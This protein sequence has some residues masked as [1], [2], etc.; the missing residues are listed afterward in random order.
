MLNPENT[1]GLPGLFP[2]CA[3]KVIEEA[4]SRTTHCLQG[5]SFLPIP[6]CHGTT[7]ASLQ[8]GKMLKIPMSQKS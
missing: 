6:L 7:A 4:V 5:L 8:Q 2:P 3:T 1:D